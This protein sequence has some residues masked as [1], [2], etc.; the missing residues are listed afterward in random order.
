MDLSNLLKHQTRITETTSSLIDLIASNNPTAISRCETFHS[1]IGDHDMVGCIRKINHLKFSPK[2]I[3]CRNYSSYDAT[4]MNKEFESVNWQPVYASNDV[5][6]ALNY[7][8]HV[9]KAIFD[10]HAPTIV[11]KV[12]G[13]PCPWMTPKLR[14][15]MTN[16]DRILKKARRTKSQ[17]DWSLY[18]RLR[19]KCTNQ[20]KYAKSV[21]QR[22]L[23][24]QSCNN[25]KKF[26]NTIKYIF[27]SKQK[28]ISFNVQRD[29]EK[30][31]A[32]KFSTFFANAV[33]ILKEQSI[34]L[35]NFVWKY[36]EKLPLRTQHRFKLTYVSIMFVLRELKRLKKNKSSGIDEL[37][38]RL[39]KD[40]REHIIKPLHHIINLSIK[41]KSIPS[42]WK[43]AKIIPTHKK[44]SFDDPENYRPISVLPVLSKILERAIHE[45]LSIFLEEHNLLTEY[46]FGYRKKRSTNLAATLLV[47]NIRKEVDRGNLVGA[48][49]IDLS[50]AFDTL[51]HG[52][53]LSK[54]PSYGI[55]DDELEWFTDYLFGRQQ[56]VKIGNGTSCKE[57]VNTDVPQGSIL[58]PLLFI[59]FFNDFIDNLTV[60]KVVKYADDT[61]LYCSGKDV[62][63]IEQLLTSDLNNAAKFFD[64]NSLVINLKKGKTEVMLFGTSIRI[65]KQDHKELRILYRDVPIHNTHTYKYF[66]YI[67]DPNLT[68]NENF[69]KSYKR[70]SNR[71]RL[72]YKLRNNITTEAALY[73]YQSMILPIMTYSG[74]LKLA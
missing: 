73:I 40:C 70:F 33:R 1:S 6:I 35:V 25:A 9:V 23:L 12:R 44:G 57:M 60:A 63:T 4:Q 54:L 7:F 27:P 43:I 47:D 31:L 32:Q 24:E 65:A 16:R 62:E 30:Q 18:K 19:N 58:G 8:N 17:R 48:V 10:R 71:L 20:L 13:K 64:D 2:V 55:Q 11:K 28:P 51:S 66:G 50:K 34:P 42:V 52:S 49:F 26:W 68:L 38:P 21:F 46:Q 45:Q 59:I 22:N 56:L 37:P 14:K 36:T 74:T 41:S 67:L 61:V 5:N 53:L 72:L 39:L 69:E 15:T 29:K 3:I